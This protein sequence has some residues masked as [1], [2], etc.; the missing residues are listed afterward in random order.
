[1]VDAVQ[2]ANQ[3]GENM[4][5]TTDHSYPQARRMD[6]LGTVTLVQGGLTAWLLAKKHKDRFLALY[7]LRTLSR[8]PSSAVCGLL[9]VLV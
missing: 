6:D 7:S 1:M 5:L 9:F 8:A 2:G 4:T 3:I